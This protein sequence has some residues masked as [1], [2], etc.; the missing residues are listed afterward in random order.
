MVGGADGAKLTV[1]VV[2]K[3]IAIRSP[4]L[5]R[6]ITGLSLAIEAIWTAKDI[7]EFYRGLREYGEEE[8]VT[9]NADSL[10][11]GNYYF[12]LGFR[13]RAEATYG[14]GGAYIAGLIP[15][16]EVTMEVPT[17]TL[18][19]TGTD[20]GQVTST[21]RGD[22]HATGGTEEVSLAAK[23]EDWYVF[24]GWTGDTEDPAAPASP[25]TTI[26]MS[27]SDYSVTAEFEASRSG[28][29]LC[30]RQRHRRGSLQDCQLVPPP[31]HVRI[32]PWAHYMFS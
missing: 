24:T 32:G 11:A 23:A 6:G 15:E 19:V 14:T 26:T 17:Y 27:D 20:G 13:A 12:E 9:Y 2:L 25:S 10:S 29:S 18:A 28:C 7:R 1:S 30:R 8:V 22:P 3:A 31:K 21:R 16:I 4:A 5:A